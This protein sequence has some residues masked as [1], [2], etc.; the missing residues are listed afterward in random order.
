MRTTRM[1]LALLLAAAV[2]GCGDDSEP[3]D[4]MDAST[5]SDTDTDTDADTDWDGPGS[6][7]CDGLV[8]MQ[9]L[10]DGGLSDAPVGIE[11]CAGEV[12][13]RYDDPACIAEPE[14]DCSNEWGCNEADG[15]CPSGEACTE[16]L[17]GDGCTCITPCT[18][19]DDC[20]PGELC[21]CPFGGVTGVGSFHS[22][23]H[24]IP[25][26]CRT[27]ADCAPYR[28]GIEIGECGGLAGAYCHTALDECEGPEQ[29]GDGTELEPPRCDYDVESARWICGFIEICE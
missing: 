14:I 29:C 15:G 12:N 11:Q 23:R 9:E 25:A 2:V 28:C 3:D 8:V 27:D 6:G 16:D 21:L 20:D 18:S 22:V 10:G 13:H 26:G 7:M 1:I 5:D 4:A 24:C 17:V 19:D